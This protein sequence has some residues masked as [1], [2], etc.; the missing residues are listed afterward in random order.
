MIRSSS[1]F[2]SLLLL[3]G[4]LLAAGCATPESKGPAIAPARA[5]WLQAG[6]VLHAASTGADCNMEP[7][8]GTAACPGPEVK[9]SF[10]DHNGIPYCLAEVPVVRLRGEN[11]GGNNKDVTWTLSPTTSPDGRQV[12]FHKENGI[13]PFDSSHG[14]H[15]HGRK[16]GTPAQ[17]NDETDK[18]TAKVKRNPKDA[19]TTYA[20]IVLWRR[21]GNTPPLQYDICSSV[22]PRIVNS[23]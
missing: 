8:D 11:T 22:D 3:S 18:F 23:E 7:S 9:V 12:L 13:L 15:V 6:N 16:R 17:G 19:T 5:V 2:A 20:V 1:Q 4:A 21:P 10:G 14:N